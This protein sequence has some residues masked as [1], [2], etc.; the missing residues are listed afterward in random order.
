MI[1]DFLFVHVVNSEDMQE[2][3][4]RGIKFEV[5]AKLGTLIDKD[6]NHRVERALESEVILQNTGRVAFKSSM[7][8]VSLIAPTPVLAPC[9]REL[10][11]SQAHH[12]SFN[13]LLNQIV[14]QTH[15]QSGSGRVQ[16]EY[17]HRR[18]IDRFI[19]LPL[20]MHARIP[21]CMRS[22]LGSRARSV[23]VRLTYD[24]KTKEVLG[25][26]I[27]AR[28]ADIDLHMPSCP[29]DCRLSINLEMDWDG[30]VQELEQLA[31][32]Q[33]DRQPDRS[34]DRLSYT[35]GHYQIDLTQVTQQIQGPGVSQPPFL[36]L[37][38]IQSELIGHQN[39]LR[40]GKEH[41]LE[42]ELAPGILI[43]QGRKALAGSEHRYQELVE[44]FVDNIRVLARKAREYQQ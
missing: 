41:E 35:H 4:S 39:A 30:S 36:P 12:K 2:I 40:P 19:E 6:T 7:T 8:E 17:K 24:Q 13:D 15:P 44:G 25:K 32:S 29:M 21:G 27:K 22:R 42:I 11:H 26:I 33:T 34:K 23:K 16:L 38:V 20:D 9:A 18:E 3:S 37:F 1:A 31:A 14:V 5:E 43:D 10:T 28:V